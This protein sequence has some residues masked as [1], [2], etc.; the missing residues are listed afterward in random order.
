MILSESI[1]I[2]IHNTCIKYYREK[3]YLCN[4]GDMVEIKVSDLP[5]SSSYKIKV[6]CD[7]C[8]IIKE[9]PFGKYNKNI[10]KYGIYTCSTKCSKFKNKLTCLEL[11]NNENYNNR[12]K[13]KE[14]CNVNFG[15]DN[16]MKNLGIRN[17][18]SET[19][20]I[21]YGDKIL[22]NNKE[23]VEKV[24]NTKIEI[25][26][27]NYGSIIHNK[28][29]ETMLILYGNISYN[30]RNKAVETNNIKFGCDNH[31]MNKDIQN[32]MINTKKEKGIYLSD[33]ERTNYHNYWLGVK[34]IT[35]RNIKKLFNN[36][37][38]YDYYDGE[39]IK[40]NLLYKYTDRLYPTVDHKISVYHGFKNNISVDF[41]GNI[42][43][44]CIT[45]RWINSS[46]NKN[47][48]YKKS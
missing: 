27:E 48:T 40:E 33:E 31:M 46:K 20:E 25:Y 35:S 37:N 7:C 16:P 24:I 12:E 8:P 19:V 39:D 17:K 30:N 38:G 15:C 4:V 23:I 42:D 18:A 34:R 41:I 22:M 1:F 43:N 28:A 3:G 47:N 21:I 10:S 36:W 2:K 11:Y 6:Q 32:K 14:T 29:L 5:K 26:G 45:K 44:L 13:S 9:I